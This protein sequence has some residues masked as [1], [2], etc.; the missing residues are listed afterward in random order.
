MQETYEAIS[1][2]DKYL[3]PPFSVIDTVKGYFLDRK[4]KWLALGIKSEIG[5]DAKANTQ[6]STFSKSKEVMEG[7]NLDDNITNIGTSIFNPVICELMY[8]WFCLPGGMIIDPFAGGSVRGIVAGYL[9]YQYTGIE[10]RREQVDANYENLAEIAGVDKLPSWICDDALNMSKHVADETQ[11]FLF[12]CPPYFNLEKYSNDPR[13]ISNMSKDGFTD[14]YSRIIGEACATLKQNRFAAV[15]IGDVRD[16]D[17]VYIDFHGITVR[18]FMGCGMKL[19]NEFIIKNAVGTGAMRHAQFANS[20][21]NV[22]THQTILV[23]YKG[24]P[25]NI[26]STFPELDLTG[27]DQFADETE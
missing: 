17:G 12:T 24:D 23:F 18:A 4:N 6:I 22:K 5:R 1:L 2:N 20:R 13:D 15:V 21:K 9:G 19:Y 14:V 26:R 3:V 16:D 10:L 8:K 7:K 27:M 25:A 11:D